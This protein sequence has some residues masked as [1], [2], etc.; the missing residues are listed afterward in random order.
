LY[1]YS[2]KVSIAV[3][4]VAGSCQ[5]P[6]PGLE[7]PD[8]AAL[9]STPTAARPWNLQPVS[10]APRSAVASDLPV[11][12]KIG[13]VNAR[14]L[15]NKIFILKDLSQGLDRLFLTETWLRE[16]DSSAELLM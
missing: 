12:T 16:D 7:Q 15:A 1:L 8:I 10:W 11:L 6:R 5:K 13:L 14:L 3:E 9:L 2:V 4:D